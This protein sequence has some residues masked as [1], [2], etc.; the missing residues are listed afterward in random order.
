MNSETASKFAAAA[1]TIVAALIA[2]VAAR[3][4]GDAP[5]SASPP[6]GPITTGPQSPIISASGNVNVTYGTHPDLVDALARL[7]LAQGR[8]V[9]EVKATTVRLASDQSHVRAEVLRITGRADLSDQ[10]QAAASRGDIGAAQTLLAAH[11]N[12]A[13]PRVPLTTRPPSAD[14]GNQAISEATQSMV[15]PQPLARPLPSMQLG[16]HGI[17]SRPVLCRVNGQLRGREYSGSDQ[18]GEYSEFA[19]DG[20][21]SL[22]QQACLHLSLAGDAEFVV[23]MFR[24]RGGAGFQSYG[25]HVYRLQSPGRLIVYEIPSSVSAIRVYHGSRPFTDGYLKHGNGSATIQAAFGRL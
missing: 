25:Q 1:A 23:V 13:I 15:I 10:V 7:M 5:K 21:T 17:D 3:S 12:A 14:T 24:T 9:E 6:S 2:A 4:C 11:V 22:D 8:T 16:G 20:V 19:F 18:V